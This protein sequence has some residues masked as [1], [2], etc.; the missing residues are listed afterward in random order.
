MAL[1]NPFQ[2]LFLFLL[3]TYGCQSDDPAVRP[4]NCPEEIELE[5]LF[6]L[7]NS[8]SFLPY[9]EEMS[10]VIF[11]DS[12]SNELKLNL[13]KK[14]FKYRKGFSRRRNHAWKMKT[15]AALIADLLNNTVLG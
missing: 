8:F 6:I 13:E 14:H 1:Y 3:L 11:V 10:A 2:L 7:E 9:N 5:K 4:E 12:F 15:S